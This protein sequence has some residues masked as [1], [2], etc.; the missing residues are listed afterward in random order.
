MTGRGGV[1]MTI[2][3]HDSETR[4][5]VDGYEEGGSYQKLVQ[6]NGVNINQIKAL[7][8]LSSGCEQFVKFECI[9]TGFYFHYVNPIACRAMEKWWST[10]AAPGSGNTCAGDENCNCDSGGSACR[11]EDSGMLTDL[12]NLPVTGCGL[13]TL[14]LTQKKATTHWE[15]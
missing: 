6:Y 5:L 4:T 3:S 9:G 2:I 7:I 8:D 15:N 1:G 10:G 12:D 14:V 13:E 11:L